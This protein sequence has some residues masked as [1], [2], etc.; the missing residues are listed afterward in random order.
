MEL[1][2]GKVRQAF[3]AELAKRGKK[4]NFLQN[5]IKMPA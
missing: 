3:D 4:F 2:T 1:L 5:D